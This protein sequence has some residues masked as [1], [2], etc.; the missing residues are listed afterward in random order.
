[1]SEGAIERGARDTIGRRGIAI[2]LAGEAAHGLLF[3]GYVLADAALLE[4][5]AV[6]HMPTL[7]AAARGD[8]SGGA[9]RIGAEPG[10]YPLV[11]QAD[12]L[13]VTSVAGMRR[14]GGGLAPGG[15]V[16][17]EE[18]L[19]ALPE[20]AIALPLVRTAIETGGTPLVVDLVAAAVVTE[21]TGAV[22]RRALQEA[23]A[24]LLPARGRP[25]GLAALD[26]GIELGK[27]RL[28]A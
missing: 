28:R 13:L 1:M 26:A 4:R 23:A 21:M 3:A 10:E 17:A 16:I 20:F 12:C 24:R 18:S 15:R 11:D 2:R 25:A 9:I 14:Y 22:S 6:A 5:R 27:R 7:G 8:V 19:P